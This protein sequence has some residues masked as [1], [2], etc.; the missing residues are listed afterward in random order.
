[1]EKISVY[2][3]NADCGACENKCC[4]NDCDKPCDN[5]CSSLDYFK[6]IYSSNDFLI[7]QLNKK[8]EELDDWTIMVV[9]AKIQELIFACG[10]ASDGLNV[11]IMDISN[12][13]FKNDLKR[14]KKI[15]DEALRRGDVCECGYEP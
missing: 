12:N 11:A 13:Q 9:V 3:D 4:W 10:I 14:V 2:C 1:M 5:K 8:A 15:V 7:E 6:N